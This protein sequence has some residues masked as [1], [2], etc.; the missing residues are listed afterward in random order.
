MRIIYASGDA[1]GVRSKAAP[2]HNNIAG[3][4]VILSTS[5]HIRG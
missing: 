3:K 2:A 5:G 4:I 1:S